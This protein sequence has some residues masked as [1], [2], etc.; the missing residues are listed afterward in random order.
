MIAEAKRLIKENERRFFEEEDSDREDQL[1]T[2]TNV[3]T[4]QQALATFKESSNLK[5]FWCVPL[6]VD[7]RTF[8][9][10]KLAEQQTLLG[11]RPFDVVTVDPPWQLSSANP[12]RGVAISYDTL[13]DGE[14]MKIPFDL[15]QPEQGFLL[16]WV[17]NAKYRF[18][19]DMMN[20][21]GY[22]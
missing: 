15:L 6:S 7:V 13:S 20:H 19:L 8:D 3:Q 5:S 10:A 4:H 9:F 14:I 16:V 12:T 18:A 22:K 21:Y 1:K 11:G 2:I 17:I